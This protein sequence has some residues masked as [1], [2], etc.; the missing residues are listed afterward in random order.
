M[1]ALLIV[2]GLLGL[3]CLT[4]CSDEECA[5]CPRLDEPA[6]AAYPIVGYWEAMECEGQC[7]ADNNVSFTITLRRDRTYTQVECTDCTRTVNGRYDLQ[8]DTLT[9]TPIDAPPVY[10]ASSVWLCQIGP[11]NMCWRRGECDLNP[12]WL[13]VRSTSN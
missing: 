2:L 3:L 10:M 7:V 5:T 11:E 6:V 13:F 1:K 8:G 4:G 9:L 12:A